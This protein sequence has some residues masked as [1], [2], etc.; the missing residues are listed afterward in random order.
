MITAKELRDITAASDARLEMIMEWLQP[1]FKEL[2]IIGISEYIYYGGARGDETKPSERQCACYNQFVVPPVWIKIVD[3]LKSKGFS[4]KIE[5]Y[6]P[7][8]GG[9]LG[10]MDDEDEIE[11]KRRSIGQ[12]KYHCIKI[13]W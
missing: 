13:R 6:V 3:M 4:V 8:V 1:K 7:V 5:T 11:A 12:Y 9:G 10:C 2:A